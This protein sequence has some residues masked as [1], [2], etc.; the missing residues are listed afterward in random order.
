MANKDEVLVSFKGTDDGLGKQSKDQ[1]ENIKGVGDESTKT[2][3][4]LKKTGDSGSAA[5]DK[6]S[7]GFKVGAAAVAAAGVA[8]TAMIGKL[9]KD[10]IQAFADFEQLSGGVDKLFGSA[11]DSVM[12]S[13]SDAY[14][15]AGMSANDYMEN[16]TGFSASLISGLG[17]DTTKA[18]ALADKAIRDMSDNANTYGTDMDSIQR[19]YQ[20]FAKSQFGMLDNLKLGYGGSAAEMARLINDSGVLGS[21]MVDASSVSTVSMDKIIEAVHKTQETMGIAGTTA[22][23]AASTI[24][25]S[26]AST[27]AAWTNT[28]AML[29]TGDNKSIEKALNGLL[30]SAGDFVAN[31]SKILPAVLSGVTGLITSLIKEIPGIMETILPSL[32]LGVVDVINGLVAAIPSILKVLTKIIPDLVNA[33]VKVFLSL[34]DSLPQIIDGVLK[35]FSA[36]ALAIAKPSMIKKVVEALKKSIIGMIDAIASFLKDPA[37]L[38]AM[39]QGA[40]TLFLEIIKAIPDILIALVAALPDIIEGIVKFLSD[41]KNIALIAQAMIVLFIGLVPLVIAMLLKKLIEY[42][43]PGMMKLF[44]KIGEYLTVAWGAIKNAAKAVA[45]WFISVWSSVKNFLIKAFNSIKDVVV[46][47]FNAI[48]AVVMPIINVITS[49]IMTA[50]NAITTAFMAIYNVIFWVFTVIRGIIQIAMTAVW[51]IIKPIID[52]VIG[53]FKLMYT[54]WSTVLAAVINIAKTVWNF[55][56]DNIIKPIIDLVVGYFTFLYNTW[57]TIL[58]AIQTVATTIWDSIK[59]VITGAIDG[60]KTVFSAIVNWFKDKF[61]TISG[62]ATSLK[63]T[64]SGIFSGIWDGLKEGFKTVVNWVI[65]GINTLIKGANKAIKWIPGVDEIPTIPKLAAG[66][67]IDYGTGGGVRGAGTSTSDSVPAMLSNGEFVLKAEA[68]KR[69]GINNVAAMNE[70]ATPKSDAPVVGIMN[71]HKDADPLALAQQIGAMVRWA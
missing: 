45:D 46:T 39:L 52:F 64:I 61:N 55:L 57:S 30:A 20:G 36:L 1:K 9:T 66:G 18:A 37:A 38:S 65:S 23:E 34:V 49:V 29:A 51:A 17:G 68:V 40:I 7:Q 33:F 42:L 5:G 58:S 63:D 56:W 3:D 53:Y 59:A 11:A 35:L 6:I 14:K 70:G 26:L 10:S 4:K 21:A 50:I 41:G 19:T 44:S 16:V 2:D 12:A 43:L 54:I 13:A 15:T 8:A 31:I 32:I 22:K 25:G 69:L 28:L 27:K 60:V 71:V 67:Y 47:V 24:S 62:F 48:K